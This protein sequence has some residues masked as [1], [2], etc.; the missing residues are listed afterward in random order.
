MRK[1]ECGALRPAGRAAAGRQ[2]RREWRIWSGE[3]EASRPYAPRCPGSDKWMSNDLRLTGWGV[4]MKRGPLKTDG[5]KQEWKVSRGEKE[6]VNE[7]E[8]NGPPS[9]GQ[10]SQLLGEDG[11][12]CEKEIDGWQ[13]L[14][15]LSSPQ[16]SS[17]RGSWLVKLRTRDFTVQSS[18][19]N[20]WI[21]RIGCSRPWSLVL[22]SL[23]Q[24]LVVVVAWS[25]PTEPMK[26]VW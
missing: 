21:Y 3:I 13:C 24:T 17:V 6:R 14:S 20:I 10:S 25:K 19:K 18:T 9:W 2:E 26:R 22:S 16:A 23:S 11:W 4:K 5:R 8:M 15:Y 12:Q 7:S 1:S